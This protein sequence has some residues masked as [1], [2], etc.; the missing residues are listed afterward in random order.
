MSTKTSPQR[1]DLGRAIGRFVRAPLRP[2]SYRTLCY[3]F[4]LFPLGIAYFTLL[5]VGFATGLGLA[6]VAVGVPILAGMLVLVVGIAGVERALVRALL[7]VDVRPGSIETDGSPWIRTKR[8]VTDRG[9]W[10]TVVYLLSEFV[11]GSLAFG[12]VT[13]LLA[14]SGSFLLAPLYYR[15]APVVAYGPIP[16]DDVTLHLLFGWD[17]LMIGLSTTF[18]VGSWG[19]ETLPGALLVAGLGLVLLLVSFHLADALARIWARYAQAML[20]TP[21]YWPARDWSLSGFTDRR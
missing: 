3:L 2:R 10:R 16:S 6:V 19:I 21:R 4:L 5:T 20:T 14:T 17:N 11:Y 13:S 18:R 1:P 12:L 8:L 15:R 9:T 7:D